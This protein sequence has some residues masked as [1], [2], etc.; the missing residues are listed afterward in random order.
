[1]NNTIVF[2]LF[3]QWF[4]GFCQKEGLK[5]NSRQATLL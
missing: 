3:A 1:M 5:N 4:V 2:N